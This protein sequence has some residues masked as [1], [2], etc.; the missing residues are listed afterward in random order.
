MKLSTLMFLT[1]SV[2]LAPFAMA[3]G[4]PPTNGLLITQVNTQQWQIRLISGTAVER[5]S[6]VM[7][8]DQPITAVTPVS[9]ESGDSATLLTP[10]SLGATFATW[11][12]GFDGVNFSIGVGAKL[13]LRNT[14]SSGVPMYLGASLQDATPVTAPVALASSDAC[15]STTGTRKF[16][17]GQWIVMGTNADSQEVMSQSI[18]PGVTGLVKRYS[19][20]SM[21]PSQGVYDFSG[22]ESGLGG[23]ERHAAYCDDRRQDL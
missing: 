19:W 13:C 23:G 5:F 6:G 11:P 22:L 17:A 20:R 14:G 16:H 2:V 7:D 1:L 3:Q 8:S 21:E 10:T 18:E 4:V 15:G 9:L 12:G